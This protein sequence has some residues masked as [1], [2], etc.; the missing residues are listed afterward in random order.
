MDRSCNGKVIAKAI[1]SGHL[2]RHDN[3]T[4]AIIIKGNVMTLDQM[5]YG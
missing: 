3:D 2:V 1:N 4:C 5:G